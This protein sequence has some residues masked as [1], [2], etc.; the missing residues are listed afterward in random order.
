MASRRWSSA[1]GG[2]ISLPPPLTRW[3]ATPTPRLTPTSSPPC[4]TSSSPATWRSTRV[5]R[6]RS[7][8]TASSSCPCQS[9]HKLRVS[10]KLIW[11][12]FR[13]SWSALIWRWTQTFL[14]DRW[15]VVQIDKNVSAVLKVQSA[16]I[17]WNNITMINELFLFDACIYFGNLKLK[18]IY[19]L[20]KWNESY[21]TYI[22][23]LQV[24]NVNTIS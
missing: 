13:V 2:V 12:T 7:G 4:P 8:A 5:R 18:L 23:H 20:F 19:E 3:A 10:S 11:R 17:L 6:W 22:P 14:T 16:R 15:Y 9:F 24:V 21:Y 1:W